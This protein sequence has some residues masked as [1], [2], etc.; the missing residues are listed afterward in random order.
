MNTI[1][2]YRD[3]DLEIHHSESLSPYGGFKILK[4]VISCSEDNPNGI[5]IGVLRKITAPLL[6]VKD[7]SERITKEELLSHPLP[8]DRWPACK[9]HDKI[10]EQELKVIADFYHKALA[11][12]YPI[13]PNMSQWLNVSVPT[14]NR[15]IRRIRDLGYV[16]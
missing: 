10:T 5:N 2:S 3:F 11:N 6:L 12:H 13:A 9:R 4:L 15:Y 8:S 16:S 7:P 14:V 1:A